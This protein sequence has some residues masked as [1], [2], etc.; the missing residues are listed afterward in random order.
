MTEATAGPGFLLKM[1][2][3][4]GPEV[5]TT[6]AEVKDLRGPSVR[7]DTEDATHQSSP[8]STEEIVPTI[9]RPGEVTF[10][11]N[12]IPTSATHDQST[13]FLYHLWAKTKKNWQLHLNN[14]AASYWAFAAYVIG[15]DG[16]LPVAGISTGSVTLKITGKPVLNV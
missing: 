9:I 16:S 10:D 7:V 3:G 4:A 8:D 14:A 6:V 2:D 1:G 11:C 5:F 13:G 12:F 15:F